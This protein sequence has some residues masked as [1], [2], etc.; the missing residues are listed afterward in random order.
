M[1]RQRGCARPVQD[2]DKW[3]WRGQPRLPLVLV[4]PA[5]ALLPPGRS[6]AVNR[7]LLQAAPVSQTMPGVVVQ[8]LGEEMPRRD[9]MKKIYSD[10]T[11]E[12]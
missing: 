12:E 10:N 5:Q 7:A 11:C 9:Q 1:P 3:L 2:G 6:G 8:V 4:I